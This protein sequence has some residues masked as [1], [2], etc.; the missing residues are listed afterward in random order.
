MGLSQDQTFLLHRMKVN[1][2]KKK[3]EEDANQKKELLYMSYM[4]K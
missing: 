3:K 1:N 2:K 4:K